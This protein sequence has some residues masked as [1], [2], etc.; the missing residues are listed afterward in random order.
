MN[1]LLSFIYSHNNR[2]TQWEDPRTQ[3]AA[4]AALSHGN[5]FSSSSE[6]SSVETL[7]SSPTQLGTLG[8]T[9]N[10]IYFQLVFITL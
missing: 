9:Q 1:V 6:H 10:G 8:S 3:M 5:L 7:F 4:S 2:T